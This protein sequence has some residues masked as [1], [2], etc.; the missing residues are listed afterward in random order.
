MRRRLDSEMVARGM[1][2]SRSEAT[3][4]I[5]AGQVTVSGAP[6]AKSSRLV[7]PDEPIEVLV[8]RRWVGRGAEKLDHALATW[9]IDVRDRCVIDAGSSTGGFTQCLLS[10]GAARVFAVDVGRNQLHEKLRVD[11]RVVVHEQ[12]DIRKLPMDAIARACS[13]LVA[14]LSFI[15]LVTVMGDLVALVRPEPGYQTAELV[16]LVKPQFEVGRQEASKTRGVIRDEELRRAALDRVA[17]SVAAHGADVV[18][19]CE[20]PILGAEGN[21]EY[22]MHVVVPPRP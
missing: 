6:A 1:T 15:S 7:A 10:R 17:E 14:D 8:E 13:L 21:V 3:R 16:L 5:E 22:L 18:G 9:S 2:D 12:T 19:V 20:S 4:L 11:P